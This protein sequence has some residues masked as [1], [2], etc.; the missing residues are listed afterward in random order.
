LTFSVLFVTT[1][2][3]SSFAQTTAELL[4]AQRTAE[5][6]AAIAEA[7]RAELLARLPPSTSKPLSGSVDVKQFGAA[8]LVKAFDLAH[9]L[10]SEVCA[11]LPDDRKTVVYEQATA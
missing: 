9:Q 4:A 8:G 5:T 3:P 7:E 2:T 1:G 10:A 11:A 6:R